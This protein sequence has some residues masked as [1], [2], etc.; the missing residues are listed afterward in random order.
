MLDLNM[1]T[2]YVTDF[3]I[4]VTE[5]L[6]CFSPVSVGEFGIVYRGRLTGWQTSY[7]LNL[8]AVKTLKGILGPSSKGCNIASYMYHIIQNAYCNYLY[9]LFAFC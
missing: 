7:E 5:V 8:V 1:F 6:L 3:H 9:S 4:F 2:L